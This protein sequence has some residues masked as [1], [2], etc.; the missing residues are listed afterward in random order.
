M[1]P[2]IFV[3]H[4]A[5]IRYVVFVL[6][7]SPLLDPCTSLAMTGVALIATE[8]FADL[9]PMRSRPENTKGVRWQ[10]TFP[11]FSFC[12]VGRIIFNLYKYIR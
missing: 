5:K 3:F 9:I 6:C 8:S 11:S 7:L 12:P 10:I 1:S 4:R 2:N